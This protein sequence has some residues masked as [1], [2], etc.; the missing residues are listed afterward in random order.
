MCSAEL[1]VRNFQICTEPILLFIFS[2]FSPI[3]KDE[4][5]VL[6]QRTA[7]QKTAETRITYDTLLSAAFY[8]LSLIATTLSIMNLAKP[9]ESFSLSFP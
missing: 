9:E 8:Y 6:Q 1:K 5:A 2:F 7:A 4:L 3:V